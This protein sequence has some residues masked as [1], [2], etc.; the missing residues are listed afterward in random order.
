MMRKSVA[1]T[2]PVERRVH[3]L[4][5]AQQSVGGRVKTEPPGWAGGNI[6]FCVIRGQL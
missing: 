2:Q 3:G 1:R 5:I 4:T 6:D